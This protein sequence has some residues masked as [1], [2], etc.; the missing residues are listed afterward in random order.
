MGQAKRRRAADPSYGSGKPHFTALETGLGHGEVGMSEFSVGDRL[1]T[2]LDGCML[3]G[4]L[5]GVRMGPVRFY[6][7]DADGGWS[8][9]RVR[10]GTSGLAFD[11][12]NHLCAACIAKH[13]Q[14]LPA[15]LHRRLA[16]L[17]EKIWPELKRRYGCPLCEIQWMC[18]AE[19]ATH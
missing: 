5:A 13:G 11:A 18:A 12:G 9:L 2:W 1:V 14:P 7:T 8:M 4:R 19:E 10:F 16:D 6:V 17:N 3:C 15:E